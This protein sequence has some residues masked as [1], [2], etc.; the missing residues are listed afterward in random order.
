MAAAHRRYRP[1]SCSYKCQAQERGASV[2]VSL[3]K[4]EP[5]E[6][7]RHLPDFHTCTQNAQGTLAAVECRRFCLLV[8]MLE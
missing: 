4:H 3:V 1:R 8:G 5:A 6:V 2:Q 7:S